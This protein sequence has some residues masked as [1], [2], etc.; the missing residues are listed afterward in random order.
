MNRFGILDWILYFSTT[1]WCLVLLGCVS[2]PPQ[3]DSEDQGDYY[4]EQFRP[5]F[6]YTPESGWMNDPNGM[7]F[8]DGEYHLFYQFY[9]YST[10]WGPMHWGHAVSNDMVNWEH[11]P[12]AL[13]PDNNG[14][15]FS[16]SAV[17]DWDNTSGLQEGENPPMIAIFTYHD[18]LG[19]KE[20]RVD[21]Q[22]QG[23]AY[24]HDKGRNWEV[25]D[26][27]PVLRNPGIKDFRDPKVFWHETTEKW[28]MSLAVKNQIH[29][30][31]SPNLID[32]SFLSA[33]GTEG[34]AGGVWECPDLFLLQDDS[35]ES[36]WVLLV[37]LNPGGP[38]GG[39]ATQYFIGNFDGK[40]FVNDN[41]PAMVLWLDFG[42]DNYAGVTWSDIPKEDGR[43]LFIGWMS[44]W[45]YARLPPT[46]PWRSAMTIPR[47][48]QLK[49]VGGKH[50]LFSI[51]VDELT[52]LRSDPFFVE[53]QQI[54]GLTNI[55]QIPID[56]NKFEAELEI[57]WEDSAPFTGIRLSNAKGHYY[58]IGYNGRSTMFTS[59][60][61]KTGNRQIS[62]SFAGGL[63]VAPLDT[64]PGRRSIQMRILVDASSIELFAENGALSMTELVFPEEP[65]D[66]VEIFSFGGKSFVKE[67]KFYNLSSVW[68]Q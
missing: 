37:S 42:R 45:D 43:K 48:L 59:D 67:A 10:V 5:Q 27:N 18:M 54:D 35:G 52:Q 60:R 57:E 31:G 6:H 25:Y 17:I 4:Q 20:G 39:S 66:R 34:Q 56:A 61:T 8:Y 19:E 63:H 28:I 15:I 38:N 62:E 55:D 2:Q 16:G 50:R 21:F 40:E 68:N 14:Q 24:S 3:N 33:F 7:V 9:P 11:L 46:D 41:D 64:G 1:L 65:F 47:E 26:E 49:K 51:P 22:T 23:I 32:W 53:P 44:N 58:Q 13:Y 12:V 36:K 29:F 30:Y